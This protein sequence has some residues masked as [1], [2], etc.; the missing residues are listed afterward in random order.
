[1]ITEPRRRAYDVIQMLA[2]AIVVE[3][4]VIEVVVEVMV[5]VVVAVEFVKENE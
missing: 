5:M 3:A 1:M 2:E 4:I